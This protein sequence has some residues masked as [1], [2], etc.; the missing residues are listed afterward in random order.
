MFASWAST[1]TYLCPTASICSGHIS[2]YG[3]REEGKL[4]PLPPP[5]QLLESTATFPL[6][7]FSFSFTFSLRE[8]FTGQLKKA[9][10]CLQA[11]APAGSEGPLTEASMLE[12]CKQCVALEIDTGDLRRRVLTCLR[13]RSWRERLYAAFDA[14]RDAQ[15]PRPSVE[16]LSKLMREA[17]GLPGAEEGECA[18]RVAAAIES[19]RAMTKAAHEG[20]ARLQAATIFPPEVRSTIYFKPVNCSKPR[21]HRPETLRCVVIFRSVSVS[22]PGRTDLET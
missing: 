3:A 8:T 17:E 2:V 22:I 5:V 19:V 15:Q 4:C 20:I 16:A 13:L 21:S 9:S 11:A 14:P 7:Q 12:V 18:V 10:L 1:A 6:S